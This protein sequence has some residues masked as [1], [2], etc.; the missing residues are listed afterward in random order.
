MD[1]N[2]TV[3]S[4]TIAS[5]DDEPVIPEAVPAHS[6]RK[7]VDDIGDT[8][9]EKSK[10]SRLTQEPDTIPK[11][12]A[13]PSPFS[14]S[15]ITAP[16]PTFNLSAFTTKSITPSLTAP[17]PPAP[18]AF[19]APTVPTAPTGFTG[20]AGPAGPTA[21]NV[22]EPTSTIQRTIP[23]TDG[24][25]VTAVSAPSKCLTTTLPG[26]NSFSAAPTGLKTLK[27]VNS[28]QK[29]IPDA[30]EEAYMR[31]KRFLLPFTF[32]GQ[33]L[34]DKCDQRNLIED[35]LLVERFLKQIDL[36]FGA[37]KVD[38][39]LYWHR[40]ISNCVKQVRISNPTMSAWFDKNVNSTLPWKYA[41]SIVAN[42]LGV[43]SEKAMAV[44]KFQVHHGQTKAE[45]FEQYKKRYACT[46]EAAVFLI[47]GS[48]ADPSFSTESKLIDIFVSGAKNIGRSLHEIR[49]YFGVEE[50]WLEFEKL[51]VIYGEQLW[52]EEGQAIWKEVLEE[53]KREEQEEIKAAKRD[54][55]IA[56]RRA[57][58]Q[59]KREA[60]IEERRQQQLQE[61]RNNNSTLMN[62][63]REQGLCSFCGVVK[64]SFKHNRA[65]E[66]KKK[67]LKNGHMLVQ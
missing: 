59:V 10:K 43:F 9:S 19:A 61:V 67:F 50:T 48:M 22:V 5:S 23:D 2:E 37:F 31:L 57:K 55:Q 12:V 3:L 29:H 44:I 52:E 34:I 25:T 8:A 53:R 66:A 26:T 14:N 63:R 45:N 38:I 20:P 36:A 40:L 47:K 7:A 46:A 13:K 62:E 1:K 51:M 17:T 33:G 24:H 15:S 41:R 6:K 30:Q 65:C 35:A 64:H 27:P 28:I 58:R 18:T 60:K 4:H 11:N 42:T 32:K 39:N 54:A 16:A 21:P 56:K 49:R